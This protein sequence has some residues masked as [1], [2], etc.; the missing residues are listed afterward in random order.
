MSRP[1][2]IVATALGVGRIPIAPGTFGTLATL[3]LVA[4]LW[5]SG[6]PL[7]F[8]P[9]VLLATLLGLWSAGQTERDFGEVDPGC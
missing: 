3:P 2:R 7:L 6:R 5:W 8:L 1:R 9:A 4:L